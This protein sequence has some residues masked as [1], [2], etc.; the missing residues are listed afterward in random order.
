MSSAQ[1]EGRGHD[2]ERPSSTS[3]S[4]RAP[5][6]LARPSRAY[7]PTTTQRGLDRAEAR[8]A[9]LALAAGLQDG[10]L[11]FVLEWTAGRSTR[12]LLVEL[13]DQDRRELRRALLEA[14]GAAAFRPDQAPTRCYCCGRLARVRAGFWTCPEE[15]VK[16]R[17]ATPD[18]IVDRG[19]NEPGPTTDQDDQEEERDG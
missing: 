2:Q 18:E 13:G 6:P 12:L 5:G 17:P 19:W 16:I 10:R 7:G 11:R 8:P 4:A 1:E 3:G 14:E 15:G 9:R